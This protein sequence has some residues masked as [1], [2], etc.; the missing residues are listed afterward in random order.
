M[1]SI[2]HRIGVEGATTTDIYDA[3][4]TIDGL[5]GWWT[6]DVSGDGAAGGRLEFRFPPVGGF[7]ME[8]LETVS[9]ESVRWRVIE[10]P[11]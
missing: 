3:L 6:E 11:D 9:A 5:A 10:G 2:L 4:T 1:S 8:V 7:D